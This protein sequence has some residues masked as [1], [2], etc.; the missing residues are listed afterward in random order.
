MARSCLLRVPIDSSSTPRS[1][2]PRVQDHRSPRGHR[3]ALAAA[4]A[5]LLAAHLLASTTACGRA[6]AS[7]EARVAPF[8]G[9]LAAALPYQDVIGLARFRPGDLIAQQVFGD[10]E[11]M[12][13][14]G[15]LGLLGPPVT[16]LELLV[17]PERTFLAPEEPF[18]IL[19]LDTSVHGG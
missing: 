18:A 4:A 1:R 5:L 8:G 11:E 15:R 16:V 13:S 12:S 14:S 6:G 17:D 2:A 19:F 3:P 10:P 7:A 9:E